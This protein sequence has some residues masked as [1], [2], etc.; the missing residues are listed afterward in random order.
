MGQ[1]VKNQIKDKAR[2]FLKEKGHIIRVKLA[3]I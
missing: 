3:K 1:N 2:I